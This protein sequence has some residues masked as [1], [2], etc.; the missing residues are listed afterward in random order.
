MT[1][2]AAGADAP[3]V[4]VVDD[5]ADGRDIVRHV[6]EKLG[7]RVMEA[8]DGHDGLRRARQHRPDL[9]VLD[10]A[11]PGIDGWTIARELRADPGTRSIPILAFTAHAEKALIDRAHEMGCDALL[12]KPCIPSTLGSKVLEM[13]PTTPRHPAGQAHG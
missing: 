13:I 6:V 10:L 1:G 7:M 5:F 3:L 8:A 12:T 2:K 11:L 4:L 9:L